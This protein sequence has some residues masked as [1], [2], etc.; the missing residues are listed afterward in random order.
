MTLPLG[1][2]KAV[3]SR[4]PKGQRE[5]KT[6]KSKDA[7]PKRSNK[8]GQADL[9]DDAELAALI[10]EK[11]VYQTM[12]QPKDTARRA[13]VRRYRRAPTQNKTGSIGPSIVQVVAA[14]SSEEQELQVQL[15]KGGSCS[16]SAAKIDPAGSSEEQEF[17]ATRDVSSQ[18]SY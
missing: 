10:A 12:I 16:V 7:K 14:G 8:K 15:T 13:V 3:R 9:E 4:A 2:L 1:V 18:G 11:E 6:K 5:L 17:Q